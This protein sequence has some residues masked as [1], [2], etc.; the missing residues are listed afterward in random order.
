MLFVY[1]IKVSF[2]LAILTLGYR[3]LVQF[4]TFPRLNRVLLILNV[5]AA[6]VIPILP[7]PDWGAVQIQQEFHKTIP[8][9]VNLAPSITPKVAEI[10]SNGSYEAVEATPQLYLAGI[11][12]LIYLCGV[13]YMLFTFTY[14]AGKLFLTLRKQPVFKTEKGIS[15]ISSPAATSPYSFFRWIVYSPDKH[16]EQ[17]LQVILAHEIT[18]ARQLHSLDLLLSEIQRIFLWFNP[19]ARIHQQ[20]V[21]ENLEYLADKAVLEG[22]FEKKEY[23]FNLLRVAIGTKNVP[24]TNSFTQSLLKKRIKMMNRKPSGAS[25]SGKY[26]LLIG[27]L[28][29]SSAFVAPYERNI[30]ALLPEATSSINSIFSDDENYSNSG[31]TKI[32]ETSSAI[33]EPKVIASGASVEE[34]VKTKSKWVVITGDTLFWTISPLHTWEDINLMK[35]DVKDFGSTLN[36]NRIEYD[37]FQKYI[38]SLA[39]QVESRNGSANSSHSSTE[40]YK[41]AR[42]FSGFIVRNGEFGIGNELPPS[43][44]RAVENDYE[45]ALSIYKEN[46][47]PYFEKQLAGQ[48]PYHSEYSLDKAAFLDKRATSILAKDG[49]GATADKKLLITDALNT[50][51]LYIN[52]KPANREELSALSLDQIISIKIIQGEDKKYVSIRRK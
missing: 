34:F 41:P 7:L 27:T 49:L 3:W 38:T 16:S 9:I 20:C 12:L 13:I 26:A 25:V 47:V 51:K 42:A 21:Q 35:Q 50:S 4:E 29:I 36:I 39:V 17:E 11:F 46:E 10:V 22:S 14:Q 52:T 33:V 40:K 48:F 6:W 19:F 44:S 37:P 18:H 30:A 1:L 32:H 24:L 45:N 8:D 5:V 23:Q 31:N 2:L 15:L 28:Y 43:L